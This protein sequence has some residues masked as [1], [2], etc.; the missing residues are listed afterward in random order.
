MKSDE[1][2]ANAEEQKKRRRDAKRW[3]KR[4]YFQAMRVEAEERALEF[5]EARVNACTAQYENDGTKGD[6]D[7][8]RKR[9]EDELLDYVEKSE[10]VEKERIKLAMMRHE[11]RKVIAKLKD[12][13]LETIVE[14]RYINRLQWAD[15][16][17]LSNY[18]RAQVFRFHNKAIEKIA[19]ILRK[20]AKHEDNV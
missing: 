11:T 5:I 17:K 1:I 15:V 20:E 16:I 19:A 9:R 8:S 6:R 4:V 12:P 14:N 3:L 2:L 10:Q 13:V 7:R 18:S